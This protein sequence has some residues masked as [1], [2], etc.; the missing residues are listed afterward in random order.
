MAISYVASRGT[1]RAGLD[2]GTNALAS[3]AGTV[4]G[5]LILAVGLVS[6]SGA[7]QNPNESGWTALQGNAGGCQSWWR[8]ANTGT[9]PANWTW[10][11]SSALYAKG[12]AL[13]TLRGVHPVSPVQTYT[14]AAFST[15]YVN[16]TPI[17]IPTLTPDDHVKYLF[18]V[19]SF[20][21]S[22]TFTAPSQVTKD[23]DASYTT[24]NVTF[25]A[26]HEPNR[27]V[28]ATGTRTWTPAS[29][30]S[31]SG[32]GIMVAFNPDVTPRWGMTL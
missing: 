11:G 7:T 5:D 3:P 23:S 26:G 24:G 27:G 31:G 9:D 32:G 4:T 19:V 15:T 8:F 12:I 28:S 6:N 2:G 14:A 13:F 25:A 10:T 16:T 1:S 18:E 20:G 29:A 30:S 22:T 21:I 17:V